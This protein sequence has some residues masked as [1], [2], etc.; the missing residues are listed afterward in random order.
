[1][2]GEQRLARDRPRKNADW[3]DGHGFRKQEVTEETENGKSE[4]GFCQ[5]SGNWVE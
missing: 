5:A 3:T 2:A 1:M 4:G